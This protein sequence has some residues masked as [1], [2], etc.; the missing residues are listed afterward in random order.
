MASDAES[1]NFTP[2]DDVGEAYCTQHVTKYPEYSI[3]DELEIYDEEDLGELDKD[4]KPKKCVV[5]YPK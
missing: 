5:L 1:N 4:I 3:Q 2:F